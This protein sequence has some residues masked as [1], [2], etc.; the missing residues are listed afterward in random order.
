MDFLTSFSHVNGIS[1]FTMNQLMTNHTTYKHYNDSYSKPILDLYYSRKLGEKDQL[2][3]NL[4]G[5]KFKTN[6]YELSQEWVTENGNSVFNNKMD[7]NADQISIVGEVAHIHQFDKGSLNSGV[8]VSTNQIDNELVNLIGKFNYNV[9][10]TENYFYS[11]YS[12]KKD[13][14]SYRL[15]VGLTNIHNKS[16]EITRD[17]WTFTPKLVLG[18]ELNKKNSLRFSSSYF[19][20]SP[21][22]DALSSNV[23]QMVPNIVRKGNPFLES[24]KHFDNNLIY[25]FNSKYFDLNTSLRYGRKNN[26]I[27]QLFLEDQALGLIA[28]TYENSDFSD[29]YRMQLTGSVKPFGN[30]LLVLKMSIYPTSQKLKMKDGK[31]LKND[32]IGNYFNIT[33]VYKNFTLN[34]QFNIPVYSLDGTFLNTNENNNHLFLRYKLNDWSFTSGVYW[35]G[36][37]S[38]YKSK[39]LDRSI[40]DY[41]S[42]TQIWNNKNMFVLGLSYDFATGKRTNIDKKLNNNTADAAQF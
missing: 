24:Q 10:Y 1:Q 14:L 22:S 26:P 7:L 11:E 17:D 23:V 9:N 15:G 36:A 20:T 34:Y 18:Y 6:A 39:S 25:S 38:E 27:N 16:A 5:S 8:R 40:V 31:I 41:T 32:Y 28:L 2:I 13:K 4:V 3:F 12:G 37:P 42:N 33:S 35:L 29:F 19:P 21:W 30:D